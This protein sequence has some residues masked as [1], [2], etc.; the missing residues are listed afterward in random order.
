MPNPVLAT[1]DTVHLL[2]RAH[3]G[4]LH[5]WLRAKLGNTFDAADLAQDTFVRVLR[6]RHELDALREPRAYLTTIAKRLLMN[7][8]RRRSVEQAYLEALALM[9]EPLAPSVEQRLIILEALQEIDEML[10]GLSLPARQAFLMAQL[11][12]LSHG[13]IA[14]R[15]NVSLRSVHRYIAKGF[16]QCIMA[17]I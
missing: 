8:H 10:A 1:S 5:G 16:E 12:G 4:W 11:E 17:A 6:H 9:P 7:H 14:A 3:H 2:Y 15:L 13:E